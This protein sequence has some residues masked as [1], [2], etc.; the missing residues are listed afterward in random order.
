VPINQ[1]TDRDP[2]ASLDASIASPGN[3]KSDSVAVEDYVRSSSG[4]AR[5][6]ATGADL[7]AGE[8]SNL[9][10]LEDGKHPL[11][12]NG[13]TSRNFVRFRD[14]DLD[15]PIIDH[16]KRVAQQHRNRIAVTDSD[17]SLSYAELWGGI[18]GL[19]E[20]IAAET[21][22]GDLIGI[23]LPMC[24][25]F[26]LA[27][28]ACLAAGRPFVAL[29]PRYPANWLCQVL[30]DARPALIIG[31]EEVPGAI[32]TAAPAARVIHL[33]RLPQ[34]ARKS[35][36]PAELGLD[37]PAC[38]VFTS[39][40]TGR[41]KGIVNS[42]RNL[43][44]R[45]AQ[46]INAAH[47]N[48]GDRFLTLASLCTIVGV[49]DT[50]TALLAGAGMRLLDP[51]LAGA[52]EILNVI[53][54]EAITILFAFPA[55][56]RSV[57]PYSGKRAGD[58][59]A[60]LRLVRVG[61]DTTLWD[62]IDLLRGWL[63]PEAAIQL[64][65]A[66]TEA[67]MMQ[68]FV[69]VSCRTDEAR[70]PIGYPLPGNRLA[71]IDEHGYDTPRGEVG[72]LVVK[73][74][75]VALG[76]WVDGRWAGG[77]RA[78]GSV[79]GS[80]SPSCRLFRTGDLVR[81]RPDGLLERIGRKDRQIKIR[82]ARVDLDGVEAALRRHPFVCDVGALARP[83]NL[84][85]AHKGRER[86]V[87]F[88]AS[89]GELT[90]VAY[91]SAR[92]G[93]NA[94]LLDDLK[95]TMRS[96]PPH[97]R[98]KRLYLVHRIPRLPS[99]KLDL[100]ALMALDEVNVQNERASFAPAEPRPADG[101]CIART[102]ARVWRE[103][104]QTPLGGPEDDFFDAGGDSLKALMFML[105]LE[106]ALGRELSLTLITETPMFARLCDSLREHRT[107]G[108]VPLVPLKPGDGLPPV[109]IIHHL[110]GNVAGLF[111]MTR[112]MTW[113]GAVIGIQAR[114][115]D[116]QRPPHATVEAMAAEYLKEV[117]VRQPD[118]PYYLCGYSFG[119][120]VAFEM[121]RR[122]KESGDEVGLVGLFDTTMSPLRW[123]L[124][125]WLSIVH[126]RMAQFAAA[127]IAT[128]I[129]G[130]PSAVSRMGSHA[131]KGLGSYLKSAPIRVF[132]VTACA[133]IASARY[134]PGFYPGEL[135]LFTPKEREPGI[136]SP[137]AIWRKHARTLSIVETAGAHSTIFSA[138]NADSTAAS[139]TQCLLGC[140]KGRWP[141]YVPVGSERNSF[142]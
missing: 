29:D 15:R 9:K 104:L 89:D 8:F 62:D 122:L 31:S 64:I 11:D 37:Q 107:T 25:M 14:D 30:E 126:R 97:M 132:K 54:E 80:R 81:Q 78:V 101:D 91:V 75:Y 110:G 72:E 67:P 22:P 40:S 39:G 70:I 84:S 66:A 93:A 121:A 113:P 98:P 118:G 138:T 96:A 1:F 48:A 2:G 38:V 134:R 34:A 12:W 102:V 130:W 28:L 124:R 19:G 141:A 33:T 3:G 41:P 20:T 24:S 36:R 59:N 60:S 56:L 43:L 6:G 69:D 142:R 13:P 73:S 17:T 52:R 63:R 117:K 105:G 137:Q 7:A 77:C 45:V 57:I 100:H 88:N 4:A 53:R 119:G 115:L 106:R 49:R 136:P 65:Y 90:L 139:L 92:G 131:C 87:R 51:Q 125:S 133:L 99:S 16:F 42:Q 44:Q 46:S 86:P 47:I 140:S 109:F 58:D 108:Y 95:E 18:S 68:W 10:W 94:R 61:G 103:V 35:W 32:E 127:A 50:I 21:K 83:A 79:E 5:T 116:G 23:V 112:R 76:L 120:L 27:M 74:P 111:P 82:G 55:L 128:P 129:A 71:L 85:N 114:G 123:P 26:P 135:T